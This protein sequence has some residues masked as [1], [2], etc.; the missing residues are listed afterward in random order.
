MKTACTEYQLLITVLKFGLLHI[1]LET[2]TIS[3]PKVFVPPSESVIDLVALKNTCM[4][5]NIA[6]N[7]SDIVCITFPPEFTTFKKDFHF[8]VLTTHGSI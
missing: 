4:N 2:L 3:F 1:L 7:Q 6:G 5:I 8:T